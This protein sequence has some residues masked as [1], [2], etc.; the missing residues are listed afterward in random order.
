MLYLPAQLRETAVVQAA[1][2]AGVG[3]Y[4][5]APY[6]MTASPPPAILLGFSGLSEPEITQGV[7]CLG[8]VMTIL[9]R[10]GN[11]L[12]NTNEP[13]STLRAPRQ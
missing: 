12:T 10:N 5:A 4:P 13:Q 11:L 9:L 6:F 7:A 1:S 3:V 8:E 2:E